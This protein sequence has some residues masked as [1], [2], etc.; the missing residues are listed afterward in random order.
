MNNENK[1]NG[2]ANYPTWCLY[3]WLGSAEDSGFEDP[4]VIKAYCAEHLERQPIDWERDL[5]TWALDQVDW[6]ELAE[7]FKDK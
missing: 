6:N 3:M 5:L 7:A 1:Y 2:W 4:A